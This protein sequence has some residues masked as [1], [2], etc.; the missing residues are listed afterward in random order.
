[1]STDARV[2]VLPNWYVR[3]NNRWS[4]LA[5]EMQSTYAIFFIGWDYILVHKLKGEGFLLISH[6]MKGRILVAAKPILNARVRSLR[7]RS[8]RNF[9]REL[10]D[11]HVET[12]L[13]CQTI[14][15]GLPARF[16]IDQIG[17]SLSFM[18]S[19]DG[20]LNPYSIYLT[21]FTPSEVGH[22]RV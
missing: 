6:R 19:I 9:H 14:Q 2:K 18:L 13:A 15:Q 4:L 17:S 11:T 21:I 20:F 12:C 8:T 16:S 5:V 1:M 3:R 10:T 7:S 22:P